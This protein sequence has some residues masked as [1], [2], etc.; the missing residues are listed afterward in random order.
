VER[1]R[2]TGAPCKVVFTEYINEERVEMAKK[3]KG[4]P[5]QE[6]ATQSGKSWNELTPVEKAQ[7]FDSSHAHPR[8]YAMKFFGKNKS[9]EGTAPKHKK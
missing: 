8:S 2:G 5:A 6:P 3:H 9:G 1:L 4:K 7:E